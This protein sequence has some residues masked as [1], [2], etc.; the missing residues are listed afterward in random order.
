MWPPNCRHCWRLHPAI[1]ST[2]SGKQH[3]ALWSRCRWM[4]RCWYHFCCQWAWHPRRRR[5]RN[6]Q[7]RRG[8]PPQLWLNRHRLPASQVWCW[9]MLAGN[10]YT[11]KYPCILIIRPSSRLKAENVLTVSLHQAC[12]SPRTLQ[13]WC[14]CQ[15]SRT[16]IG[17][18]CLQALAL[19]P[20]P[21][22]PCK[23][24][25]KDLLISLSNPCRS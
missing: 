25:Q 14:P 18:L 6:A 15:I 3:K 12:E 7:R 17:L 22:N 21:K 16:S 1:P 24:G 8:A 13:S 9:I 23:I 20:D 4:L 2:T 19:L 11:L 5:H 10:G